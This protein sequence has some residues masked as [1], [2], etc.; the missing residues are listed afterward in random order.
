MSDENLKRELANTNQSVS[1]AKDII[2]NFEE[3][4]K[5]QFFANENF[6][7]IS[8]TFKVNDNG[9][10]TYPLNYAG[11]W[12]EES[13]LCVGL[14]NTSNA[15]IDQFKNLASHPMNIE[16]VERKYSFGELVL[17]SEYLIEHLN[18]YKVSAV[19]ID[20]LNNKCIVEVVDDDITTVTSFCYE[21][22]SKFN[23][24]N[25]TD[26]SS[27][28]IVVKTGSWSSFETNIIGGKEATENLHHF[29]VGVCGS[30]YMSSGTTYNGFVTCGH[31]R[32]LSNTVNINGNS[33]GTICL[34]GF[35]NNHYGDYSCVRMTSSDT[36]TNKVYGSSTST[37]R[38]ITSTSGSV[39][40]NATVMKFGYS[41]GYATATVTNTSTSVTSGGVT[42]LGLEEC[43]LTSGSSASGDSGGP[44]YISGG[45]GNNYTFVGVHTSHSSSG[46]IK[47]TPYVRFS[48][49][50]IPKTS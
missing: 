17:F 46:S 47:F 8:A 34:V 5:L 37:T 22:V 35:S 27:D 32:T 50:F 24:E 38:N 3:T 41:S 13:K 33:F 49:K 21:L 11:S 6:K 15:V 20:D 12:I 18:D 26:F 4:S 43:T 2:E 45:S 39:A 36:L 1:E 42:I 30:I 19:S 28:V 29:T 40:L 23:S 48:S 14:T 16:F 10:I 7:N 9:S 44:Y 25:S 31:G